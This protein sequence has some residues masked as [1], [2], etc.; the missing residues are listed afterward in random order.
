MK[1]LYICQNW[2]GVLCPWGTIRP[3]PNSD[4][5]SDFFK[6]FLF[7]HQNFPRSSRNFLYEN[8]Y[9]VFFSIASF[10]LGISSIEVHSTALLCVVEYEPYV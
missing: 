6:S 8:M 5:V 3:K 9:A 7:S 1:S 4:R 10:P 2:P